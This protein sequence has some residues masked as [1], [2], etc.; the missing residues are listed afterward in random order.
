MALARRTARE[1][2]VSATFMNLGDDNRGAAR[3]RTPPT[4]RLLGVL[5][6]RQRVVLLLPGRRL[7]LV[8]LKALFQP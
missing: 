4:A 2:V 1:L 7:Y 5:F 3:D 8:G 6:A